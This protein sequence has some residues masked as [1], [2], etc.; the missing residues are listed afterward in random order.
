M[1]E[2]L[3]A[4]HRER[5]RARIPEAKATVQ[6]ALVRFKDLLGRFREESETFGNFP[7]LFMGLIGSDGSWEHYDGRRFES[8]TP[9]EYRR[10]R[11]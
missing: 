2:P 6:A 3:T 8:P 7:T 4:E 11:A 10:R 9:R 5:I 1:R